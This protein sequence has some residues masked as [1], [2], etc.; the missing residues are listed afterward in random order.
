MNALKH[1]NR[2]RK[3][4]LLREESCAFEDRLRKWMAI[5]DAQND[6]EEFLTY[7]NVALSFELDRTERALAQRRTS[8]IEKSDEDEVAEAQAVGKRLF[9]DPAGPTSLYGNPSFFPGKKQTSWNEQ[10]VDPNDPA[11]LVRGGPEL[12]ADHA[13]GSGAGQYD[14]LEPAALIDHD[15]VDQR[16]DFLSGMGEAGENVAN[17]ANCD[18]SMSVVEVHDTFQVIANSDSFSGLDK[19]GGRAREAHAGTGD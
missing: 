9:F 18:E 6:I 2:S 12:G 11:V 16:G 17:E 3:L 14:R 19:G 4:A 5:G 8:L 1:G 7:R 10:P 13:F 15:G